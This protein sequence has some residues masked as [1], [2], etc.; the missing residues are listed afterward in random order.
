MKDQALI[1]EIVNRLVPNSATTNLFVS[2][3]LRSVLPNLVL[4]LERA[5]RLTPADQASHDLRAHIDDDLVWD[6]DGAPRCWVELSSIEVEREHEDMLVRLIPS[7][8][9]VLTELADSSIDAVHSTPANML[10]ESQ[11]PARA[12]RVNVGCVQLAQV[13]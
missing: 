11:L 2:L 8:L 7:P 5:H 1:A 9:E 13:E 4:V 6:S 10:I 3:K 12:V